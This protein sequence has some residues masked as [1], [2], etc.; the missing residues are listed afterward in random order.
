GAIPEAYADLAQSV[1]EAWGQ[2]TVVTHAVDV[3]EAVWRA[4]NDPS[5]PRLQAAGADAVALR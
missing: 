5:C 4:A 3:A 1:F 2:S